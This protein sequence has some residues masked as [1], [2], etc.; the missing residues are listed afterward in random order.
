MTIV[1]TQNIQIFRLVSTNHCWIPES[2]HTNLWIFV[3]VD[4]ISQCLPFILYENNSRIHWMHCTPCTTQCVL[5]IQWCSVA[6]KQSSVS[7]MNHE[8]C[9][10]VC[11]FLWINSSVNIEQVSGSVAVGFIWPPFGWHLLKLI[12]WPVG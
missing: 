7:A 10:L 12:F 3:C 11:S 1:A 9:I 4:K 5:C 2:M 8:L 6:G